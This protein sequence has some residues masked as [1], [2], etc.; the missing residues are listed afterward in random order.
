LEEDK[1]V[2]PLDPSGNGSIVQ[3]VVSLS[4]ARQF[5]SDQI[6]DADVIEVRLDLIPDLTWEEMD[7]L[8][9]SFDGPI[10]L[11]LRSREEGGAFS[12]DKE[13]WITR[14]I[15]FLSF[16]TLVDVE[17]RYK[18]HAG[19]LREAGKTVIASCHKN[20]MLSPEDLLSLYRELRL[21]GDIPK[22]AVQPQDT[23]D[24]LTLLQF[25]HTT[26]KPLIVSVTGTICRHARPLLP[27]FGSLY[28]YCYIDSPTSPGQYS[29]REMRLL[30]QLLAPGIMDTWF[31]GAPDQSK[32]PF[33]F[34]WLVEK[35]KN[36]LE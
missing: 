31:D 34:S 12:P 14:I 30:Y 36:R 18:E 15:P 35:N 20:E 13:A 33:P 3:I 9:S 26:G 24:L 4:S 25:T 22:I 21:Y 16:V 11:T 8:A 19:F 17:I 32:D 28:T 29:L 23:G 2:M 10:I 6:Q 1:I 27:L 7:K 5:F